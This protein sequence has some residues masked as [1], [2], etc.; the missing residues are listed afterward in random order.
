MIR[1]S[2][3]YKGRGV[4]KQIYSKVKTGQ[5]SFFLTHHHFTGRCI[6]SFEIP[7]FTWEED[8]LVNEMYKKGILK[9][10]DENTW[11]NYYGQIG[12]ELDMAA[13]S[14]DEEKLTSF[15]KT[16]HDSW[17]T[18]ELSLSKQK[19][20]FLD[21]LT[22]YYLLLENDELTISEHILG[23]YKSNKYFAEDSKNSKEFS[24]KLNKII[25][26]LSA[27]G[28][29]QIN[30]FQF[31]LEAKPEPQSLEAE[32]KLSNEEDEQEI[33]YLPAR[34][35]NYRITLNKFFTDHVEK[36]RPKTINDKPSDVVLA[37]NEN[38]INIVKLEA[39][40]CP[41]SLYEN[42]KIYSMFKY[43]LTYIRFVSPNYTREDYIVYMNLKHMLL[44]I[45]ANHSGLALQS[46][47]NRTRH[48]TYEEI[49]NLGDEKSYILKIVD[50]LDL[51]PIHLQIIYIPFRS[52]YDSL[53]DTVN[54]ETVLF[55]LQKSFSYLE[56]T[57]AVDIFPKLKKYA[58]CDTEELALENFGLDIAT[59]KS[60]SEGKQ[61]NP[62]KE[63]K[64]LND[65]LKKV[66]GYINNRI[67]ALA[68]LGHPAFKV[69]YENSSV[70]KDDKESTANTAESYFLGGNS[71]N[72]IM[73]RVVGNSKAILFDVKDGDKRIAEFN[74][75]DIIFKIFFEL[76]KSYP[77]G[78]VPGDF[79]KVAYG[80]E[81]A[82]EK[83]DEI[84]GKIRGQIFKIK[85][86]IDSKR[87]DLKTSVPFTFILKD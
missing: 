26:E 47:I 56:E 59:E 60:K 87:L 81:S 22:E 25:E 74:T 3:L 23:Y 52:L 30:E 38:L 77:K 44:Q 58:D 70:N 80:I 34:H 18:G 11:K 10:Q 16:E 9:F 40:N 33:D 66:K 67:I 63:D 65:R 85:K 17:Y 72:K 84:N 82:P 36:F 48:E 71:D 42:L 28:Y 31:N 57:Y 73:L 55:N 50:G 35:C 64:T 8:D 32:A 76:F 45:I 29:F 15:I 27:N 13:V 75:E 83:V 86:R 6:G 2:L 21:A 51:L 79:Y 19:S 7:M 1:D 54:W 78:L 37:L 69:I 41:I 43:F 5:T 46:L 49:V 4:F 14:V 39:L 20:L 12:M 24:I 68:K 61:Y 53:E 62:C